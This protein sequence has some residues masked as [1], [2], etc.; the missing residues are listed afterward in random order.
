[1]PASQYK[2]S[3]GFERWSFIPNALPGLN[4]DEVDTSTRFLGKDLAFPFLISSMSGGVAE[5]TRLNCELARAAQQSSCAL[6]L[7]SIRPVLEDSS[8]IGSF[9]IARESAPD[10][11]ILA[12]LGLAQLTK[13]IDREQV[14]SVCAE[15]G[16]DGLVIHL[17]SMQEAIQPE[18]EPLFR[19]GLE[20]LARWNREF[21]LPIIVKEVGQ[22]MSPAVVMDLRKIGIEWI[23]VAGS[24]GTNWIN[25][26]AQRIDEADVVSKAVAA[27]FHD[28]GLPTAEILAELDPELEGI[29]ASG[30]LQRPVD[31]VKAIALGASLAAVAGPVLRSA[32]SGGADLVQQE[33]KVWQQTLKTAMFGLGQADI[34]SLRGNR[35]LLRYT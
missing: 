13:G 3:A 35:A 17:N 27:E 30:G 2:G 28:W 15:M 14:S 19:D 25:I 26:E 1:M 34:K 9:S 32:M 24:G 20:H 10:A 12:N 4:L 7:G 22:G 33:L 8:R 29:I 21:T 16:V 11:V 18:G 5:A 31:L 6:G 23:D